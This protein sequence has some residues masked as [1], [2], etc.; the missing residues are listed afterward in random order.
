MPAKKVKRHQSHKDLAETSLCD[1]CAA[2]REANELLR[3]EGHVLIKLLKHA[4]RFPKFA[5]IEGPHFGLKVTDVIA[6]EARRDATYGV[7]YKRLERKGQLRGI[8]CKA[9]FDALWD[10]ASHHLGTLISAK[11]AKTARPVGPRR[12]TVE[13]L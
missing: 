1:C 8:V 4:G 7:Q 11:E 2:T 3:A 6:G 10:M 5:S 9:H 12:G 13:L